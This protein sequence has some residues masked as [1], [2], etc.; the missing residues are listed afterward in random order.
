VIEATD[1]AGARGDV[2]EKQAPGGGGTEGWREDHGGIG[3]EGNEEDSDG[4][5]NV[6]EPGAVACE[7]A[8]EG[9][10][11]G[12]SGGWCNR[13]DGLRQRF[14]WGEHFAPQ[15]VTGCFGL[16]LCHGLSE[17]PIFDRITSFE[18]WCGYDIGSDEPAQGR[19]CREGRMET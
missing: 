18:N 14:H 5:H 13:G 4:C 7:G 15:S 9:N 16:R 2:G 1:Y 12:G 17:A 19:F 11:G 3:V 10:R 8:D 6:S